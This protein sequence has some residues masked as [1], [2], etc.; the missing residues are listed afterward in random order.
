MKKLVPLLLSGAILLSVV[1]C[2]KDKGTSGT[3][4]SDALITALS[5]DTETS[6]TPDE[7]EEISTFEREKTLYLVGFQW[8]DPSSFNPLNGWPAWPTRPEFNL[9]YEQLTVYNSMSG[10]IE[11]LLGRLEEK[12]NDYVS[13]ILNNKAKWSDGVPLTAADVKFTYD[14]NLNHPEAPCSYVEG[15]LKEVTVDTLYTLSYNADSSVSDT[16]VEERIFLHVDKNGRNNPYSLADFISSIPIL[17]KHIFAPLIAAAGGELG[18]VARDIMDR[19]QV[20]SGPYNLF[21]YSNEKIVIKRRDDYWGNE[22]LYGGRQAKPEYVIHPIYKG[23]EHSS[24]ALKHGDLDISSNFMPRIWMKKG[25]GTWYDSLPYFKAGSVPMFIINTTK[26]PLNDKHYRRAMAFA[27]DYSKIAKLAVSGYTDPIQSGLI[28]PFSAESTYYSQEEVNK[29]GAT[30]FDVE[31]ARAELKA[32]GY[33]SVFE[34]TTKTK[35]G[36]IVYGNL[37][38]VLDKNGKK[39][40]SLSIKSPAGWSDFESIVKLAVKSMRE[41]GIDVREGFVDASQYWPAQHTGDFDLFMDTPMAKLSASMPWARFEKIM[42]SSNWKPVGGKMY[43]NI[44][45]FNN[46]ESENY[47]PEIDSLLNAVPLLTDEAQI[48]EALTTLNK[49]FMDEQPTLP[50]L[51]R[52]EEFYEF[53][54]KHWTNF[55]TE[56]NPYA[57]PHMPVAGA[58]TKILWEIKLA[59]EGK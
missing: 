6:E 8:G 51:Y 52:P 3:T 20:V 38:H 44:G 36:E 46:P 53:S 30:R 1:S 45:R 9:M 16:T 10:K 5:D 7:S 2:K 4:L 35:D 28:M 27:I 50:L 33:V 13:V 25:V 57:P 18:E 23:N 40:P 32:G 43:E 21:T 29:Y 42:S 12:N 17:P 59:A 55:P 26:A 48:R 58:G 54:T 24:N 19:P 22:A 34:D 49:Y 14:M 41:V 47:I 15:F 11:P 31:A 56:N 37:K 39:M